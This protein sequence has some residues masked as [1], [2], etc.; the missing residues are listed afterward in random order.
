MNLKPKIVFIGTPEFGA[1][2]LEG[3]CKA[4]LK[5]ALV[6]TAPDKPVGRKQIITPPPIKLIAEKYKISVSQ[7]EKIQDTRYEIQNTKPDLIIVA[8]Y[9]QI[10]PKEILEV[11]KYG[12]LNVHPSLL[13]KYRGSSPVQA[14]ILNGDK[15]TGVTIMLM[16]EKM[17]HGPILAQR[18]LEI[19]EKETAGML[20]NGLAELGAR[21]LLETIPRWQ[22]GLVKPQPQDETKTTY[23]KILTREDGKINWKKPAEVLEREI[24]AYFPWPG[25]HTFWGKAGKLVKIKI[26]RTRVLMSGTGSEIAYP[27]GKT[28]V[29]PQNEICVQCGKGF[30]SSGGGFLII[31]KLQVEGK[32]EMGS[33]DFLRGHPDFIGTIL[34]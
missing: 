12:C 14:A 3:L 28:L 29:A 9:G 7:P 15:K 11:P 25:S 8:A 10:I 33:E 31:E 18:A 21:L 24:R 30:S 20:H 1:I 22:K 32:K 23:T 16:D 19:E 34:K 17:D 27:I 6:I 13:P 4:N 2:V 26:L 5:P